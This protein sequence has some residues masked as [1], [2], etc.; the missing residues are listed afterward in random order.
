MPVETMSSEV[1]LMLRGLR[2]ADALPS[3][4]IQ[5]TVARRAPTKG[6]D[7]PRAMPDTAPPLD[8]RPGATPEATAQ[9]ARVAR[10]TS[11]QLGFN[12]V[13][14]EAADALA[15]AARNQQEARSRRAQPTLP[16]PPRPVELKSLTDEGSHRA[17]ARTKLGVME[18]VREHIKSRTQELS[19]APTGDARKTLAA[20]MPPFGASTGV[21]HQ[22]Q[23]MV[24]SA[25]GA[26][27][28]QPLKDVSQGLRPKDPLPA[29]SLPTAQLLDAR[30]QPLTDVTPLSSSRS[31]PIGQA[32]GI[33]DEGLSQFEPLQ[34][35]G[36]DQ[37]FMMGN[38]AA[39]FVTDPTMTPMD[40]AR[41]AFQR[42]PLG[43]EAGATDL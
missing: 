42:G 33:S 1:L 20:G 31:E 26:L 17:V 6:A 35:G 5:Q 25:S 40:V 23:A 28:L 36:T 11:G 24:R 14:L 39:P 41:E 30:I 27:E 10:A 3:N 34:F 16:P 22:A 12:Q 2:E 4:V 8:L 38:N 7:P 18:T 37:L 29:P 21:R 13:V 15:G 43:D 9:K 32:P 19:K